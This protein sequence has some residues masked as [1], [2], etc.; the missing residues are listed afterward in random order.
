MNKRFKSNIQLEELPEKLRELT[1]TNAATELHTFI[2]KV[3]NEIGEG[4]QFNI[5]IV[6]NGDNYPA[7]LFGKLS[8]MEKYHT[9]LVQAFNTSYAIS[10]LA[11]CD[12]L[13][14]CKLKFD[15]V[16]GI[17]FDGNS[18]EMEK[19]AEICKYQDIYFRLIT[20]LPECQFDKEIFSNDFKIGIISCDYFKLLTDKFP[21]V[22]SYTATLAPVVLF[23]DDAYQDYYHIYEKELKNGM[24]F[25][26]DLNI[27]YISLI[28][29]YLS[30][31]PI[32]HVLYERNTEPTAYDIKHKFMAS[33]IANVILHE[34]GDF[35]NGDINILLNGKTGLVINLIK[36]NGNSKYNRNLD[37]FLDDFCSKNNYGYIP[38]GSVLSDNSQ[39]N[40]RAMMM[41]PYLITALGNASLVDVVNPEKQITKEE[42]QKTFK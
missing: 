11:Q 34:K 33:G 18:K 41:L 25:V 12:N 2:E 16:I 28:S 24:K 36:Y 10:Y 29:L 13:I 14:N 42:T 35:T 5:M 21:H 3:Q 20:A 1:E 30:K 39:W 15:L 17:D 32:I 40:I 7:A 23:N 27:S 31:N 4:N 38:I 6:G 9:S 26:E 22:L 19:I 8:I 37:Y